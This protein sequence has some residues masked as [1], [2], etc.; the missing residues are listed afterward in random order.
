MIISNSSSVTVSMPSSPT[1]GDFYVIKDGVGNAYTQ[2][3]IISGNGNTL[4]G[5]VNY[6]LNVDYGSISIIFNGFGWNII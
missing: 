2:N 3:I 5:N 4:D 1:V 6:S